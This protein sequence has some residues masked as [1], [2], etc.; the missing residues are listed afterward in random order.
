MR[1]FGFE[2]K[3]AAAYWHLQ[4]AHKLFSELRQADKEQEGAE[5]IDERLKRA[6]H[7]RI[8]SESMVLQHFRALVRALALRVVR[9]DYPNG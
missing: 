3:E 2:E 7:D 9:R 1:D 4:R 5:G 8:A 6:F